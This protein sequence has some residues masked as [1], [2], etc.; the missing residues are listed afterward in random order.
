MPRGGIRL[1]SS[2]S[3]L[4]F[5][6]RQGQPSVLARTSN[7]PSKVPIYAA[8]LAYELFLVAYVWLLRPPAARSKAFAEIIGGQWNRFSDFLRD[9]GVAFLFW[10]V[11]IAALAA[12]Q[13]FVRYNGVQAARPL[14]PQSAP[15]MAAFL[16]LSVTAGF[17]EEFIFRGYLQRQ[18]LALAGSAWIAITLQAI[19]FGVAHIYQ[20][21][22]AVIA[23]TVYG[24]LF[25]IL[26]SMRK[27][28]RPGMIQHATQDSL[29]GILASILIKR[30]LI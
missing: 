9:V 23:I 5:A 4:G 12:V 27:S 11:V 29:S 21:W 26:A 10:L 24:S 15:E 28:L 16:V 19:V 7:L 18:F 30:K 17:C 6:A 1:C 3:S 20:G 25:G 22:R 2:P 13:V 8:T 14:L